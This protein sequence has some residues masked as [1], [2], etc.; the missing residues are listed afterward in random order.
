[1]SGGGVHEAAKPEANDQILR[2]Q[3]GTPE[4]SEG[5]P[6]TISRCV[7]G[8]KSQIVLMGSRA[9]CSHVCNF[10]PTYFKPEHV[11]FETLTKWFCALTSLENNHSTVTGDKMKTELKEM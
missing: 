4:Y 3:C 6:E 9:N 10:E 2:S 11:V 1:M 7:C 8:H 5:D